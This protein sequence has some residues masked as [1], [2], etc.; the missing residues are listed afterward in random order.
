[1]VARFAGA[2][3]RAKRGAMRHPGPFPAGSTSSAA[4]ALMTWRGAVPCINEVR[5]TMAPVVKRI[6][7]GSPEP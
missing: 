2:P 6:S 3:R 5:P 1:M 7:R 4:E